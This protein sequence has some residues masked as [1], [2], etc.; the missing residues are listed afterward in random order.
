MRPK[1]LEL[2]YTSVCA[3]SLMVAA[4]S[5]GG[6]GD[7]STSG[8]DQGRIP[9]KGNASFGSQ[10]PYG[11][12]SSAKPVKLGL[13]DCPLGLDAVELSTPPQ[14]LF[15]SADCK[16]M[17]MSVRT[18]DRTLDSFWEV[19]PDGSYSVTVDVGAVQLR[20]DKKSGGSPC[21]T[22][23]QAEIWGKLNCKDRDKVEIEVHTLWWLGKGKKTT[24]FTGRECSL[25][26]SCYLAADTTVRQCQ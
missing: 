21:T 15:L 16:D 22:F 23:T 9:V 25:P 6:S 13:W 12:V 26:A 7:D 2:I 3:L 17:T 14:P 11:S 20:S 19:L 24:G 8:E 1:I 18:G 10:C 5:C 4:S